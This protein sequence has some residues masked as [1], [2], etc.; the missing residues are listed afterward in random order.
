M[1]LDEKGEAPLVPKVPEHS[2]LYAMIG[3]S[4]LA[5]V[6]LGTLGA[7][8]GGAPLDRGA[9][10]VLLLGGFAVLVTT[11][12]GPVQDFGL[13]IAPPCGGCPPHQDRPY[14][15]IMSQFAPSPAGERP[16]LTSG[17]DSSYGHRGDPTRN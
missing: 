8:T 10:R 7:Y 2:V 1:A 17:S 14:L 11:L 9:L 15:K 5:L 4:L 13:M 6:M 3:V 16:R 12:V